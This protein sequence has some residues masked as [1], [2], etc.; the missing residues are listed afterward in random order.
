M[1]SYASRAWYNTKD[2]YIWACSN[3]VTVASRT[4]E[5]GN[6]FHKEII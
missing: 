4:T 2:N 1:T 3:E 5:I 6:E